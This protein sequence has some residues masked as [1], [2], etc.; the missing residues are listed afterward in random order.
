M[1]D[2]IGFDTEQKKP[3][4][5]GLENIRKRLELLYG[6]EEVLASRLRG[7]VGEYTCVSLKAST[8]EGRQMKVLI[9][10]DEILERESPDTSDE[11][12]V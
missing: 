9:V 11:N 8:E 12:R 7:V 10:E 6:K 3:G 1:D 2:G 4:G 5:I